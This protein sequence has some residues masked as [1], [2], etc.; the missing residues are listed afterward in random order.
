MNKSDVKKIINEEIQNAINEDDFEMS[1]HGLFPDGDRTERYL[2]TVE[3][4]RE[5][6]DRIRRAKD[7]LSTIFKFQLRGRHHDR[8]EILGDKWKPFSQN[9]VQ[10]KDAEYIAVYVDPK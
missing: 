4:N 2:F 6:L 1:G 5:G 9:D 3:N 7:A 8:K 10:L